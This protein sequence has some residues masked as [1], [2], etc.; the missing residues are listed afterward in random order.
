MTTVP[1]Q[2]SLL[3]ESCPLVFA[4]QYRHLCNKHI[5]CFF[6][7]IEQVLN[8]NSASV[9][10]HCEEMVEGLSSL[11]IRHGDGSQI[12]SKPECRYH[13]SVSVIHITLQRNYAIKEP[14]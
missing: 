5:N 6:Y 2:K 11:C 1:Q 7:T 3:H 8:L 4:V 13:I 9:R 10:Y 12:I 14:E